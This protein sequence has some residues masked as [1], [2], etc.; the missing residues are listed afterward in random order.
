[1]EGI[2]LFCSYHWWRINLEKG[3]FSQRRGNTHFVSGEWPG[4]CSEH[5]DGVAWE[6]SI[7]CCDCCSL[8]S[9][10]SISLYFPFFPRP[11]PPL[12]IFPGIQT[13]E[14]A[15]LFPPLH[16][17]TLPIPPCPLPHSW[18]SEHYSDL[19]STLLKYFHRFPCLQKKKKSILFIQRSSHS[20]PSLPSQAT[21]PGLF[22]L[23]L[24]EH[25]C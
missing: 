3:Y 7:F 11:H 21:L 23:S 12:N 17:L 6:F 22:C 18:I 25:V 1:M 15:I 16:S 20:F 24:C 19:V 4:S 10:F 8:F 14:I 13:P 9:I 2:K 5:G